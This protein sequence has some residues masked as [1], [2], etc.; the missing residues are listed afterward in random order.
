MLRFHSQ[1]NDENKHQPDSLRMCCVL[2][3]TRPIAGNRH[4]PMCHGLGEGCNLQ[5]EHTSYSLL[6]T[7]HGSINHVMS[8]ERAFGDID[9][10]PNPV[11]LTTV[12]SRA[13]N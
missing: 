9:I 11:I 13:C 1:C 12:F 6:L 4:N 5:S 3:F 2:R 8:A 7:V 10:I